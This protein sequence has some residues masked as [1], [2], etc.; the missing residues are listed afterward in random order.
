MVDR[1]RLSVVVP[2][3]EAAGHI[4]ETV[5]RIDEALAG[6]AHEVIVVDDGSADGTRRAADAAG[7]RVV[8]LPSNAGKGA[9]VRA[10]M[11]E[12]AGAVVAFTDSDLAY[13]PDQLLRLLAAVEGG[14]DVAVGSRWHPKSR[15]VARNSLLRRLSSRLFNLLTSTVL[16][17]HYRDTQCGLKAFSADAAAALFPR[18]RV[19][20]FA[21]DVE[22]LHL[23]ERDGLEVVE[24]PVTVDESGG[25]SIRVGR[26]ALAMVRDLRRI[27]R[28]SAEGRYEP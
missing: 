4:G 11:A 21:F 8:R 13:S 26:A 20:G 18:A 14:A 25:S 16:L 22:L 9:A 24:V 27:R 5:R 23:A 7:A 28:W 12:A 6:V 1:P 17:G 10:G 15:A 2:A 3:F 19:D